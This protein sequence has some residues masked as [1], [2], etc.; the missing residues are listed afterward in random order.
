MVTFPRSGSEVSIHL[1]VNTNVL[2]PGF[3]HRQEG[4]GWDGQGE[5]DPHNCLVIT[6]GCSFH[7]ILFISE[8]PNL[9]Y[10]L[11]CPSHHHK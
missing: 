8:W 11:C 4:V 2:P 9:Y 7:F 3:S 5:E 10:F 1:F 6:Q